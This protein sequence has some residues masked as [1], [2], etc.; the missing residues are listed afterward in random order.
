MGS[1]LKKQ[2]F[3]D[4]RAGRNL[5]NATPFKP[6]PANDSSE[7][8]SE[9]GFHFAVLSRTESGAAQLN[10]PEAIRSK[11]ADDPARRDQWKKALDAF[12]QAPCGFKSNLS[13]DS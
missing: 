13:F 11:W 9:P 10:M 7:S 6:E 2:I 3:Q 5:I 12:D 8:P 4:W 1:L